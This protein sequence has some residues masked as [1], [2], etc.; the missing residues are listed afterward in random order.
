MPT[1][2]VAVSLV[3]ALFALW[4]PKTVTGG[5]SVPASAPQLPTDPYPASR[6]L[7][8]P[9]VQ[10]LPT[11]D[12][13][14]RLESNG[15]AVGLVPVGGK[16]EVADLAGVV[17]QQLPVPGTVVVAGTRVKLGVETRTTTMPDVRGLGPDLA[18]KQ[19]LGLGL[20][21]NVLRDA[22]APVRQGVVRQQSAAPGRLMAVG[23]LVTLNVSAGAPAQK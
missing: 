12:A 22:D 1:S 20:R 7:A 11:A 4:T 21:V 14:A 8:V 3:L 10:G 9:D 5:P 15:L 16:D 18:A 23:D 17:T 6:T 13:R 2:R 19:L